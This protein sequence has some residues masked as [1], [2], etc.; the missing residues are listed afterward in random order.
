MTTGQMLAEIDP[1][2]FQVAVDQMRGQLARDQ[3]QFDNA[4]FDL[5]RCRG[6]LKQDSIAKQQVN[7]QAA[8]V[9]QLRGTVQADRAQLADAELQLSFTRVT[10]PIGGRLGLRQVDAGNQVHAT[11]ANGIV[12]ITETQPIHVVFGVPADHLPKILD[13]RRRGEALEVGAFDREGRTA[14]A[15]GQ[16]ASLD[17]QIDPSTN[18]IKL[19]AEFANAD[20]RLFPNQFVNVRL[21]VDTLSGATLVPVAALQQGAPGAFVYVVVDGG[22]GTKPQVQVRVVK[23]GPIDNDTVAIIEG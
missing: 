19:K 22:E 12:T 10:A 14:L 18:T 5:D 1:R 17:N 21:M 13:R 6:L 15:T 9:H 8:L 7:A 3:A 4:Q 11:D 16:L 20:E 2:P 23:P